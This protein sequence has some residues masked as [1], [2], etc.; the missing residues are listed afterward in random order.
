MRVVVDFKGV[1]RAA[2]LD[3]CFKYNPPVALP[4]FEITGAPQQAFLI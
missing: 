2:R 1:R 3:I 4:S